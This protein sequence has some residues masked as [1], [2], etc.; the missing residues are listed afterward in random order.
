MMW[1]DIKEYD[2][3]MEGNIVTGLSVCDDIFMVSVSH[4]LY[5]LDLVATLFE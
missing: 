4:F 2:E 5:Y 3:K 1:V